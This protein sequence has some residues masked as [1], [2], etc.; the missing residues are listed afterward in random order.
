MYVKDV[1]ANVMKQCKDSIND[2]R[3]EKS[4]EKSIQELYRCLDL[5]TRALWTDIHTLQKSKELRMFDMFDPYG[6]HLDREIQQTKAKMECLQHTIELIEK[7]YH[8]KK[9]YHISE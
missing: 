2:S 8:V 7:N 6:L 5:K 1:V 9:L 3:N 4:Q